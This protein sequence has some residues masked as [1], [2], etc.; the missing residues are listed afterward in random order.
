MVD[1]IQNGANVLLSIF[2]ESNRTPIAC[3]NMQRIVS[4]KRN[5]HSHIVNIEIYKFCN[6]HGRS[7]FFSHV[8]ANL[9]PFS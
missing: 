6:Y 7:A 5:I 9:K 1:R 2:S 3:H 4:G 8:N